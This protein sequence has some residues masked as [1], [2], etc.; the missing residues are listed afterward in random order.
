MWSPVWCRYSPA[1]LSLVSRRSA[2]TSHALIFAAAGS[3]LTCRRACAMPARII[4]T[5]GIACCHSV[6][7]DA[8]AAAL[9][10]MFERGKNCLLLKHG[11][12]TGR[13][14]RACGTCWLMSRVP[15]VCSQSG[16]ATASSQMPSCQ[17]EE[18]LTN[19]HTFN[20]GTAVWSVKISVH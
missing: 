20:T 1:Q 10:L 15:E 12:A 5:A 4:L 11:L 3:G 2:P 17:C 9:A 14:L 8:A 16:R 7:V 18:K 13:S 6:P 19:K